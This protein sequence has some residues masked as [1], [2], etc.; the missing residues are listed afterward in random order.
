M[1]KPLDTVSHALETVWNPRWDTNT[2][3]PCNY[4]IK[5]YNERGCGTLEPMKLC[6]ETMHWGRHLFHTKVSHLENR[7]GETLHWDWP[8]GSEGRSRQIQN[9]HNN[10]HYDYEINV[11]SSR[12]VPLFQ[13]DDRP[14][15][16]SFIYARLW[17][18]G[19]SYHGPYFGLATN[20]SGDWLVG[21]LSKS[22]SDHS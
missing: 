3:S 14:K 4:A 20:L 21:K 17:A 7:D 8:K 1:V 6:N 10:Y 16:F 9:W 2:V 19:I 13:K 22:E 18:S 5:P 12:F 11:F 15:K